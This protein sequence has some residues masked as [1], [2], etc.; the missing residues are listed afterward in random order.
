VKETEE[1]KEE[2]KGK[3]KESEKE[4]ENGKYEEHQQKTTHEQSKGCH[5]DK[6]ACIRSVAWIA[7]TA[8]A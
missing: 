1:E 2:D 7:I 6:N 5:F 8:M 3:G 4:E